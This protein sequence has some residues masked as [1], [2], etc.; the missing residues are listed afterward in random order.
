[1]SVTLKEFFET[2]PRVAIA[3]SG[4][5]DSSYLLSEAARHCE[6]VLAVYVHSAFQPGFELEDASRVAQ[7]CGVQLVQ[8][9]LDILGFEEVRKNPIDRCYYC[10]LELF[11]AITK[12]AKERG[13][14][15]VLEGTNASD[16]MSDRPGMRALM[17]LGV[18]SPLRI[19]GVTKSDIREGARLA[20]LH[21]S[22]KPSYACLATRFPTGM[23]I[24]AEK[25]QLVERAETALFAMGFSDFR[26]R[27]YH[28]AA[29]IQM[30]TAQTGALLEKRAEIAKLL[31]EL[32]FDAVTLDLVPR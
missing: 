28:S 5:V 26:V 13:Y 10:K 24:D 1:M 16:D 2:H 17:E 21:N 31:S 8:L 32:G 20:G 25:L 7:D 15:I 18:L 22:E 3:L 23:E 29:R 14:D 30:P 11:K 9:R 27:L 4:G 19:C 12:A 6:S